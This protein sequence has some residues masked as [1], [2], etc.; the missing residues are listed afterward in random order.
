MAHR[1]FRSEGQGP[2]YLQVQGEQAREP[3]WTHYED[4]KLLKRFLDWVLAPVSRWFWRQRTTV[5]TL[6]LMVPLLG[7]PASVY[8]LIA[9][10]RS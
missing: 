8:L 1:Y 7:I 5:Q 3:W 9:Y 2:S 10:L 6:F 4:L